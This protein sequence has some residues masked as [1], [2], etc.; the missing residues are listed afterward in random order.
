[1]DAGADDYLTKPFVLARISGLS[2]GP[3][4][5]GFHKGNAPALQTWS[6][7]AIAAVPLQQRGPFPTKGLRARLFLRM[8]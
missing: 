4:S 5:A 6:W 3:G 2:P 1:L 8:R 7:I